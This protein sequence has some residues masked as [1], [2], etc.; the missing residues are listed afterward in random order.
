MVPGGYQTNTNP[1]FGAVNQPNFA[2]G[3]GPKVIDSFKK[4][5]FNIL[6]KDPIPKKIEPEGSKEF[7]ELFNLADN[8][9]KDRAHE[10]PKY[11]LSYNPATYNPIQVHE[12]AMRQ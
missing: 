5:G 10:K 6:G 2:A 4:D 3:P 1:L 11:D 7:A 8:K 12:L 9:I